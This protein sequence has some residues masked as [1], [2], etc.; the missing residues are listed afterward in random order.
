M[1]LSLPVTYVQDYRYIA[2]ARTLPGQIRSK[3]L[4]SFRQ[5][6]Q[7]EKSEVKKFQVLRIVMTKH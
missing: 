2:L 5:Q 7:N 4:E 6:E 1:K 3:I